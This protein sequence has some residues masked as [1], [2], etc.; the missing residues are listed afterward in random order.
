MVL[1]TQTKPRQPKVSKKGLS[2]LSKSPGDRSPRERRQAKKAEQALNKKKQIEKT[3]EKLEKAR[4]RAALNKLSK[5]AN[6]YSGLKRLAYRVKL[7]WLIPD[8]RPK[9]F[10]SVKQ[11]I[12]LS[13]YEVL[14]AASLELAEKCVNEYQHGQEAIALLTLLD[15][16]PLKTRK[17]NIAATCRELADLV[18]DSER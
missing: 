9:R 3:K 1:D 5:Q 7:F 13:D 10:Y 4:I 17:A 12:D 8:S 11:A 2:A 18:L 6:K 16:P 15:D 14:K